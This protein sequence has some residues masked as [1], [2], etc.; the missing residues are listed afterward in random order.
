MEYSHTPPPGAPEEPITHLL[1]LFQGDKHLDHGERVLF[2]H[3]NRLLEHAPMMMAHTPL[4]LE[5]ADYLSVHILPSVTCLNL[6]SNSDGEQRLS[7]SS[8][9]LV[10]NTLKLP[11]FAFIHT[12]L[13]R[14]ELSARIM[15]REHEKSHIRMAAEHLESLQICCGLVAKTRELVFRPRKYWKQ[16]EPEDSRDRTGPRQQG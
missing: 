1:V 5:A 16:R 7:D 4:Q 9:V 10:S 6:K 3:Q 11:I 13:R 14:F 2:R 15:T 8:R 12:H